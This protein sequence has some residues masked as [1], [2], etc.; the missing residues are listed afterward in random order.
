MEDWSTHVSG[1]VPGLLAAGLAAEPS[2]LVSG[3]KERRKKLLSSTLFRNK[4]LLAQSST[5]DTQLL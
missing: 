3:R 2:L 4:H 1:E 5:N